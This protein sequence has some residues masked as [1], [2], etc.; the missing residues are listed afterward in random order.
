M[1]SS[2]RNGL[3]GIDLTALILGVYN[4]A[5]AQVFGA[6]IPQSY[7]FADTFTGAGNSGF[8]FSLTD[9]SA[10]QLQAIFS[11][12]LRIGLSASAASATGGF[13]TFFV[14]SAP[15]VSA[16]PEPQTYA[17]LLA[18]LGVVV[19]LGSKRHHSGS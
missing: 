7:N 18:G 14:A 10:A 19:F 5:G 12:D 8:V 11:R 17:M 2:P 3:N 16:V 1:R 15:T 9:Q 13:E 6:S 4:A